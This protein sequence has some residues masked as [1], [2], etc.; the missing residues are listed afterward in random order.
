V[1][2]KFSQPPPL[3]SGSDDIVPILENVCLDYQIVANDPLYRVS[4]TIDERLQILDNRC[5]KSTGH[6]R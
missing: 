4:A 1:P 3:Q 5:R 6:A 2:S